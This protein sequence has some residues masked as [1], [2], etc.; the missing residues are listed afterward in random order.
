[1]RGLSFL[2]SLMVFNATGQSF[3]EY[4]DSLGVQSF[5]SGYMEAA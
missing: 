2:L 1:M 3:I 4:S 5:A